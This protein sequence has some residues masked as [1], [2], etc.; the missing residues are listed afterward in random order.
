M[1]VRGMGWGWAG[2]PCGRLHSR[3]AA[4]SLSLQPGRGSGISVAAREG[5]YCLLLIANPSCLSCGNTGTAVPA[6]AVGHGRAG[7]TT[8]DITQCHSYLHDGSQSRGPALWGNSYSWWSQSH[9]VSA[10]DHSCGS[11]G[12]RGHLVAAV[13]AFCWHPLSQLFSHDAAQV[14]RPPCWMDNLG[15]L[16]HRPLSSFQKAL[17]TPMALSSTTVPVQKQEPVLPHLYLS[18][19]I[20]RLD[21]WG[22]SSRPGEGLVPQFYGGGDPEPQ[23]PSPE[24]EGVFPGAQVR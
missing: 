9:W 11:R 5:S 7:T 17:P 10:G 23:N 2:S 22:T 24:P 18:L 16:Q 8:P 3:Q 13:P 1:T 14:S 12:S 4:V 19:S 15:L 21:I 6:A 20:L